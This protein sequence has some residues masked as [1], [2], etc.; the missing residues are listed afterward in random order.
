[1]KSQT[2]MRIFQIILTGLLFIGVLLWATPTSESAIASVVE[3]E[4]A[5]QEI[6]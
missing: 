5:P 4:S 3:I 2:F 6:S 1:M